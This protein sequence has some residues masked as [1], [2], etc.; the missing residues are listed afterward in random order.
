MKYLSTWPLLA[1]LC[2]T[3]PTFGMAEAA[4]SQFGKD[5]PFAL[6]ELPPGLLKQ[7]LQRLPATAQAK[8]MAWLHRFNF[9]AKDAAMLRADPQGGI[10]YQDFFP[11]YSDVQPGTAQTLAGITPENTFLLHSRPTASKV[12]YLDFNGHLISNTAWNQGRANPLTARPYSLDTDDSTFSSSELTSIAAIWRRIAEDYAPFDVDVTT[13]EPASFG[14]TTGRILVTRDTDANG[15]VMP[16]QGAGGVA[17]VGVFGQSNYGY[18]SPALVYFN[19]LG[20]GREDYVSEAASHEMGHNL[21]LS[22]DGTATLAYYGGHGSGETSWGP[23]MGTGYNRNVS[24]WSKGEYAGAN[25]LQDDIQIIGSYLLFRP[26]DHGNNLASASPLLSDGAGLISATTPDQD[27]QNLQP[28]NKGVI[29]TPADTDYFYLDSAAGTLSLTITPL[30][31]PSNTR[32]GNLDIVARLYDS[33]GALLTQSAPGGDSRSTLQLSV[34]P[35]RYYLAIDG[36]GDPLSPYSDYGS[37]GQYFI[38]GSHPVL[39]TDT[40]PPTPNPM[41]WARLPQASGRNIITMQ[42]SLA[43]DES[44]G[45]VQYTMNCVSGGANCTGGIW[46]S[47]PD[48]VASG[49]SANT[50]YRFQIKARDSAGNE[51]AASTIADA[52]TLPNLPPVANNDTATLAEDGSATLSVLANDSDGDGDTLSLTATT[53]PSHGTLTQSGNNLIYQ[54]SVNYNGD[55]AFGY[56]L[57][58]GFGG[59]ASAQVFLTITPVNDPPL[60]TN[61]SATVTAGKS[62]D[63]AVLA[64]DKDVEGAPLQLLSVSTASKGSVIRVGDLLRYTAG[65]RTGSETLSYQVSDG[66]ASSTGKVTVTITKVKR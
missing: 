57:S 8:A 30:R 21:N 44:G 38:T 24:Q 63:I 2:L 41:T 49:L 14:P 27:P 3:L 66:Q 64:N 54:P 60:A 52:T 25:N 11:Q 4:K 39:A 47:S 58:D 5:H 6:S 31:M 45:P 12:I 46:Q 40:T 15:N 43:I 17:Y 61:D 1:S 65:T 20:G 35:G 18:Y 48:L 62:V 42:A 22:H 36:D 56:S 23:L 33:N 19:N 53:A 32:G 10:H 16:A 9:P 26:D 37:L 59:S 13:Q 55:D 50:L 29:S 7:D 28:Q 34:N 51:G